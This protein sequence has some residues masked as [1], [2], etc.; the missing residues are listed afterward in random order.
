MNK[1]F[2][3]LFS[4]DK[5]S[6][7]ECVNKKLAFAN[8]TNFKNKDL[9]LKGY[10]DFPLYSHKEDS[11]HK[12]I[13]SFTLLSYVE[14]VIKRG[15]CENIAEC[16]CFLGHSSFAISTILKN[17]N[18]QKSFFIFD[19]FEGLSKI[20][21]EDIS[22][23]NK[24]EVGKLLKEHKSGNLRFKGNLE[25]YKEIMQSFEFIKI[26]DGWIPDR[27]IEI[28]TE[29]FSLVNI[30]VDLY[31]PTLDSLKFFYPRLISGGII[32]IDDYSR[33]YWPGADKA[34]IEFL[35]TISNAEY[36][37]IKIPLGGAIIQKL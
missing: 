30:D 33:P 1:F 28:Q 11:P 4:D 26:F 13:R 15:N 6:F 12:R 7:N 16:G 5:K 25:N 36:H 14:S 19:S 9:Y 31:Q 24:E 29:K 20:A 37:F 18:F 21:N 23:P 3:Y 27:F 10:F 35:E 17:Y 22:M 32:Y 34:V 2:K 8:W